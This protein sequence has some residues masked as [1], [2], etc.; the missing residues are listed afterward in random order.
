M[1]ARRGGGGGA[2]DS[3][4][5]GDRWDC[6][7]PLG[8]LHGDN[9]AGDL[10]EC[11]SGLSEGNKSAAGASIGG[12]AWRAQARAKRVAK[13]SAL[14]P[15]RVVPPAALRDASKLSKTSMAPSRGIAPPIMS[16]SY[17]ASGIGWRPDRRLER[18]S[19]TR[20]CSKAAD[21][22]RE[23]ACRCPT[24]DK[25]ML[26]KLRPNPTQERRLQ[27]E[28]AG[29]FLF[30][31]RPCSSSPIC[32]ARRTQ[33]P[34]CLWLPSSAP[35][36]GES[37]RRE[38]SSGATS[39]QIRWTPCEHKLLLWQPLPERGLSGVHVCVCA[40]V[41]PPKGPHGHSASCFKI[42][43]LCHFAFLELSTLR[44]LRVLRS[45]SSDYGHEIH[46][47]V[48]PLLPV[49][50]RIFPCHGFCSGV[51]DVCLQV[52]VPTS[53]PQTSVTAVLPLA[54]GVRWTEVQPARCVSPPCAFHGRTTA[55]RNMGR[56]CV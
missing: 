26:T 6:N 17:L 32:L 7:A 5:L 21:V 49:L 52:F 33:E 31:R 22:R 37:L 11:L 35:R 19:D 15:T 13:R 27:H 16:R 54:S 8:E 50:R 34:A 38:T 12:V 53:C 1:R 3:R 24:L 56:Q 4:F 48:A 39:A 55:M 14:T 41:R 44:E 23:L 30:F 28:Q 46:F 45:L 18:R 29:H 36:F 20:P 42:G 2:R 10:T 51:V 9:E 43:S 25:A 47:L 40:R